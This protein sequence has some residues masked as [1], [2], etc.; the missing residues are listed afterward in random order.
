MTNNLKKIKVL[1]L[2]NEI[3]NDH[4]LWVKACEKKNLN[5]DILDISK[6]NW[7]EELSKHKYDLFLLRQ[8][9]WAGGGPVIIVN[10]GGGKPIIN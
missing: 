8:A 7:I 10:R 1:I 3:D 9:G 2:R 4:L 6:Y 5:F